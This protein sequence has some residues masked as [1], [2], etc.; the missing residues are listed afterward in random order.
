VLFEFAMLVQAGGNRPYD[1]GPD[2]WF[3]ITRNAQAETG[4]GTPSN[5]IVVQN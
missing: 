2:G 4:D 1:I 5:L 3:V